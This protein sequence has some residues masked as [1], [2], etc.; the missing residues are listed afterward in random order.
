MMP[1]STGCEQ[2][3]VNFSVCLR[4]TTFFAFLIACARKGPRD[5]WRARRGRSLAPQ[6]HHDI[7]MLAARG[8]RFHG[9]KRGIT[10]G[11]IFFFDALRVPSSDDPTCTPRGFGEHAAGGIEHGPPQ[12]IE[13]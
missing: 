12:K 7:Y 3:T 4:F 13:N 11:H 5:L 6:S 9:S 2:S 8:F 1:S 10:A